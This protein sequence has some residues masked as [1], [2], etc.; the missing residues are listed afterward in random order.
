MYMLGHVFE[1]FV[2]I[3]GYFLTIGVA[4]LQISY[5]VRRVRDEFKNKG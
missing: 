2:L 1:F 5:F 3:N 4:A